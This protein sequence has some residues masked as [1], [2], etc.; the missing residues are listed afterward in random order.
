MPSYSG[1]LKPLYIP[2]DEYGFGTYLPDFKKQ[3]LWH[4]SDVAQDPPTGWD[5]YDT[6]DDAALDYGSDFIQRQR[7]RRD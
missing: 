2:V 5:R 3:H 4:T 6:V 1:S 7:I